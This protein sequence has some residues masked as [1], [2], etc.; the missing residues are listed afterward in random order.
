MGE[1]GVEV[2]AS[3]KINPIKSRHSAEEEPAR[4]YSKL[5]CLLEFHQVSLEVTRVHCVHLKDEKALSR[6]PSLVIEMCWGG[7]FIS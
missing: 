7:V 3:H 1:G 4:L 2:V 5:L 6:I